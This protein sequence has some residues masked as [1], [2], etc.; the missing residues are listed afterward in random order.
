MMKDLHDT[1]TYANTIYPVVGG[2]A[3]VFNPI[4]GVWLDHGRFGYAFYAANLSNQL[5]LLGTIVPSLQFQVVTCLLYAVQ[6]AILF[7]VFFAYLA[8]EFEPDIYGTLVALCTAG[9]TLVGLGSLALVPLVQDTLHGQ[10]TWVNVALAA[11]CL[12]LYALGYIVRRK[13]RRHSLTVQHK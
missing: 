1:G 9:A 12:P 6:K 4:V 13:E 8:L 11:L 3:F 2:L 5:V 7:A 10:Y